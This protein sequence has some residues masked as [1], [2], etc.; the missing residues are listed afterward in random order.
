M[1]KSINLTGTAGKTY[2]LEEI[3]SQNTRNDSSQELI[4]QIWYW[5]PDLPESN[6]HSK[7]NPPDLE[8]G[9]IWMSKKITK[10]KDPEIYES[11]SGS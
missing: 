5:C 4:L 8:I 7:P 3:A 6:P 1:P 11:I 10:V 9:Q 2:N